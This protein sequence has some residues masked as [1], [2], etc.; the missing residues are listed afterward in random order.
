M[1]FLSII[2]PCF[3]V[4][5][6]LPYTIQS[7][8]D[9]NSANDC[10]FIFI[11]D[12]ST[13]GTLEIIQ[14]FAKKD[15][16]A[17]VINQK[18]AGVSAARNA[19]IRIARGKYIL[20]LDGDDQLCPN[21]VTII[22]HHVQGTD[23]LITP[24]QIVKPLETTNTKLPFKAGIYTPYSLFKSCKLFPTAPKLVYKV[25]I[26]HDH[27]IYFNEDIH[28]GEVLAFTCAFLKY[29]RT[30]SV[31][32]DYFYRYVMRES[33]AIHAT[34]YQKDITVLDIIDYITENTDNTIQDLPSFNATLLRMCTSFTYNKYAKEG[35]LEKP[36]LNVI[37][38]VLNYPSFRI[39][40]NKLSC[41]VGYY[42]R[43]RLLA[44]YMRMTGL[45]GYKFLARLFCL[46]NKNS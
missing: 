18:N 20:P 42:S 16:R 6:Y 39:C 32:N 9:L 4:A 29:C 7:L 44:I 37:E 19:A 22:Q 43:D 1:A 36:A 14:D 30:I 45:T 38:R 13:D 5:D 24:V 40:L 35:L 26:L 27:D 3:N 25:S 31:A 10:E 23:L 21:A 2:I 33:S 17:V 8:C 12:G 41:A 28:S 46:K 34:N 15:K 11:N